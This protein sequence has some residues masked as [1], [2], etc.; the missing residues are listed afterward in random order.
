MQ[1]KR[2]TRTAIFSCVFVMTA[3]LGFSQSILDQS[4][5]GP[6][7]AY[8]LF[9]TGRGAVAQVY[10]AGLTGNLTSVKISV[11]TQNGGPVVV[12]ILDPDSTTNSTWS[13]LGYTM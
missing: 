4:F 12:Q 3:S 7:G 6:Y 13:L 8:W 10:T 9:Q 11:S 2:K 1:S 5:T